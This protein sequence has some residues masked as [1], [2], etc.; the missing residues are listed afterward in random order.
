MFDFRIVEVLIKNGRGSVI[1]TYVDLGA[2]T[3]Q[4]E[5]MDIEVRNEK[6]DQPAFRNRFRRYMPQ[7]TTSNTRNKQPKK[8]NGPKLSQNH[9]K[10]NSNRK[11]LSKSAELKMTILFFTIFALICSS[12]P[13]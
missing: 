4:F 10:N 13:L 5:K 12:F 1:E 6:K 3:T 7:K 11:L 2:E 8:Q 9:L